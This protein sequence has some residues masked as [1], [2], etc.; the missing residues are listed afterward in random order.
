MIRVFEV[1]VVEW[2][3]IDICHDSGYRRATTTRASRSLLV[4]LTHRW[5]V[6][7]RHCGKGSDIYTD[8][9]RRRTGKDVYGFFVIGRINIL[10]P[11]LV[12]LGGGP[13]FALTILMGQL[14]CMFL[15]VDSCA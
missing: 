7:K 2:P 3:G 6:A 15:S 9:H 11:H 10:E 14:G 1:V 12:F 13:A 8:F 5:N 4:V